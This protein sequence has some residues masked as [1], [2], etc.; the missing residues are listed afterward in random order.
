MFFLEILLFIYFSAFHSS[1]SSSSGAMS[2]HSSLNSQPHS[3][4]GPIPSTNNALTSTTVNQGVGVSS[5]SNNNHL[6]QYHHSHYYHNP[7]QP[8]SGTQS[9]NNRKSTG[10]NMS[11]CNMDYFQT[12]AVQGTSRSGTMNN[13]LYTCPSCEGTR[14]NAVNSSSMI[15]SP[16]SMAGAS[17]TAT[18]FHSSVNTPP[19]STFLHSLQTRA[20]GLDYAHALQRALYLAKSYGRHVSSAA[21]T[22]TT[23]ST[24]TATNFTSTGMATSS[25]ASNTGLVHMFQT[26]STSLAS[27]NLCSSPM[28]LGRT[29]FYL[30]KRLNSWESDPEF[31]GSKNNISTMAT[32]GSC[33]SDQNPSNE[34]L[35][36]NCCRRMSDSTFIDSNQS[37][38]GST[39]M[40]DPSDVSS[41]DSNVY[42]SET[43]ESAKADCSNRALHPAHHNS[44]QSSVLTGT[45]KTQ[46]H[47]QHHYQNKSQYNIHHHQQQH[48]QQQP[49]HRKRDN[50]YTLS[51]KAVEYC[52]DYNSSSDTSVGSHND[53]TVG[54]GLKRS[55]CNLSQASSEHSLSQLSAMSGSDESFSSET[56]HI[57][58][59]CSPVLSTS[60]TNSTPTPAPPPTDLPNDK[61]D[62]SSSSSPNTTSNTVI[63]PFNET[64]TFTPHYPPNKP[65]KQFSSP[66]HHRHRH[67]RTVSRRHAASMR[68]RHS[69]PSLRGK[70]KLNGLP[71]STQVTSGTATPL[72]GALS[73][74]RRGEEIWEHYR[75]SKGRGTTGTQ[76]SNH[77]HYLPPLVRTSQQKTPNITS[78]PSPAP[79]PNPLPALSVVNKRIPSL[80]EEEDEGVEDNIDESVP[81]PAPSLPLPATPRLLT[82]E[83]LSSVCLSSSQSST[84]SQ[85]RLSLSQHGLMCPRCI[86]H[87]QSL[88]TSNP[89]RSMVI[90]TEPQGKSL[91]KFKN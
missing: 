89:R 78:P 16:S 45:Q 20:S 63:R 37:T 73:G 12:F 56:S 81:P 31:A 48:H 86:N 61:D 22:T 76:H 58:A 18:G 65:P 51:Q 79:P 80:S 59:K 32:C 7:N 54:R 25:M 17:T 74:L 1:S 33:S 23:A 28:F 55:I 36:C 30:S 57:L 3:P 66:S 40:K 4:H 24:S 70:L 11:S 77:S 14:T 26:P 83:R 62:S 50:H 9:H 29:R 13:F 44:Y 87:K 8:K 39:D 38:Y 71:S 47:K 49:Q 19:R 41:Y 69:V 52:L 21:T 27:D 15:P 2:Q 90:F 10:V 91:V 5:G 35:Q 82:L 34:S 43:P 64:R 42:R 6:H 75:L 67:S 60:L 84:P 46:I 68:N 85:S 88:S 72:A 53:Q